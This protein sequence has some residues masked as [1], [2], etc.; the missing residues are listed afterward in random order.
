MLECR[1]I[2]EGGMMGRQI[3]FFVRVS[4][5]ILMAKRDERKLMHEAI[6]CLLMIV[7]TMKLISKY[8][9]MIYNDSILTIFV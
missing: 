7:L 4:L 2:F 6:Q 8:Q 3:A 5:K 1:D 9:P